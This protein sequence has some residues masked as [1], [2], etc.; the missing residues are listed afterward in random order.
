M[1]RAQTP[2]RYDETRQEACDN[3]ID[4]REMSYNSMQ[5]HSYLGYVSP[6]EYEQIPYAAQLT[7]RLLDHITKL[8]HSIAPLFEAQPFQL[9]SLLNHP[10]L[11]TAK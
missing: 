9:A 10:G 2:Q 1:K 7:V 4:D 6:N 5:K 8:C 3:V 11:R